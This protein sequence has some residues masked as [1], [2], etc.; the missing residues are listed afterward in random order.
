MVVDEYWLSKQTWLSATYGLASSLAEIVKP[1]Q[2]SDA[3][4]DPLPQDARH[5]CP[6]PDCM[7]SFHRASDLKRH[8]LKH[9]ESKPF[10]CE[11]H[12]CKYNG[13]RGFYRRDKLLSH[14]RNV[15]GMHS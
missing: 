12:G 7:K 5:I 11:V 10:N 2:S 6:Q 9:E 1:V 13:E 8:S 3:A 14:Q 15:H 4:L